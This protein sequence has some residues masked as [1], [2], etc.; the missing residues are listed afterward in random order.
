MR[1]LVQTQTLRRLSAIS[2]TA[3][4]LS[5]SA[6]DSAVIN[7]IGDGSDSFG[8][9]GNTDTP[10]NTEMMIPDMG[11]NIISVLQNDENF[12]TL[13]M[14]IDAAGLNEVLSSTN[15]FTLFAPSDAAFD[16]LGTEALDT[17]I[18]DP[19]TLRSI[20]LYHV[21]PEQRVD[22]AAATELAGTSV[23]SARED[24]ATFAISVVE[25]SLLV[26]DATVARADIEA[27]NGVIHEIDAVLTPPSA[28]EPGEE[29]VG[30]VFAVIQSDDNFATLTAALEAT[31]LGTVL[32]NTEETYTLFAPNN[33][34]F[35]EL[36]IETVNALLV[37]TDRLTDILLYHVIS[38]QSVDSA[39]AI[40]LEGTNVTSANG[41]SLALS[42]DGAA[43]MIND[44]TVINAD[45]NTSNGLIH[46]IDTVLSPPVEVD[47]I[48][49]LANLPEYS[50]LLSLVQAADLAADLADATKTS[51]LFAPTNTAFENLDS[52]VIAGLAADPDALTAILLGHVI[53]GS[54]NSS[55]A[56]ALAGQNVTTLSGAE[57]PIALADD[58]LSIG[59]ANIVETDI[60]ASN[61]IIHGIDAVL[62]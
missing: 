8:N 37:D 6:C 46:E 10:D 58:V 35:E 36:G 45:V 7:G 5:L 47:V 12:D 54:V 9:P 39:T 1:L 13:V 41:D 51:T 33:A 21:I 55:S 11:N 44:A 60:E 15:T 24:E 57:W 40:S 25:D 18:A 43:L 3:L 20:L 59:N 56:A 16:A 53:D 31:G 48:A 22:A 27:S 2:F 32:A 17:L 30:D 29:N 42:L 52:A 23:A 50:T 49:T 61:G 19:D 62:Q 28:T 34:A 26:N 14:A 38:G 4:C